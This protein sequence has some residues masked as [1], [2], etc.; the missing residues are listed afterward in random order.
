[1][2]LHASHMWV[3][4]KSLDA[5][6]RGDWGEVIRFQDPLEGADYAAGKGVDPRPWT[7]FVDPA[8]T[9]IDRWY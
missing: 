2:N 3:R 6:Y 4:Y 7:E 9:V 5:V 1:M 8:D